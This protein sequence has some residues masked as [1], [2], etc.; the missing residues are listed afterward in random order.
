MAYLCD[1]II[2]ENGHMRVRLRDPEEAPA[3]PK[4]Q[5]PT[6][7]ETANKIVADM[8]EVSFISRHDITAGFQAVLGVIREQQQHLDQQDAAMAA[9]REKIDRLEKKV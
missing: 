1:V 8:H 7:L 6:A 4:A 9:L 3:Q 2:E 5:N